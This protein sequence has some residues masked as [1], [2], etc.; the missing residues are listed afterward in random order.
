VEDTYVDTFTVA[1]FA[2]TPETATL[3]MTPTGVVV[4]LVPV[5]VADTGGIVGVVVAIGGVGGV[6]A[7]L[8]FKPILK[9]RSV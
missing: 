9:H 6:G 8:I 5:L 4:V 2:L 3:E 7:S 1:E